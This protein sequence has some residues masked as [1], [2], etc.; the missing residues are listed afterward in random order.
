MYRFYTKQSKQVVITVGGRG[1][2]FLY[3]AV[4]ARLADPLEVGQT[5][6]G[7]HAMVSKLINQQRY[8]ASDGSLSAWKQDDELSIR[9]R[10]M[11]MLL[12]ETLTFS[13]EMT[14]KML[15]ALETLPNLN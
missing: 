1:I 6:S 2:T 4:N 3:Y 10:G 13:K 15:S 11:G 9:L 7:L 14:V 8:S 5:W 12:E